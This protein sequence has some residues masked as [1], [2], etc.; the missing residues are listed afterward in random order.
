MFLSR[1]EI[2]C[3][4]IEEAVQ[5]T[6]LKLYRGIRNFREDAKFSTYLFFKS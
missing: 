5:V 4:I 2:F 1:L 3:L 6:F